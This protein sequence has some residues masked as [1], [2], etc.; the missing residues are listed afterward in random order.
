MIIVSR[1]L[2]GENCKYNGG[3]NY[4]E[5][6]CKFLEGK[7]YITICPE[8]DG[9]LTI[10]R[11]PSEISGNRVLSKNG[12]DVTENFIKGAEIALDVAFK[13]GA[14]LAILKQSSPSCGSGS[15][16]D[17]TFTGN[18]ISGDGITAA[19][20]KKHGIKVITETDFHM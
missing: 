14:E 2:V 5:E 19:L 1:C 3:N 15:I 9:G 8:C 12:K 7:E 6:V 13:N 10:P 17:G 20:L 18:K 11:D 16:Y 4:N